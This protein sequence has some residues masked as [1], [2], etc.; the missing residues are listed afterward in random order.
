MSYLNIPEEMRL[1]PQ[2]IVWRY[3]ET[4]GDKPT[5]VPYQAKSGN[6]ASVDNPKHWTDF[7]T[8]IAAAKL[9]KYD[10]L[11]FVFTS[12]DNF[13]GIDLDDT[14]GDQVAY[15]RQ[16]KVYQEFDS[17][18]EL[19][20]SGKGL[21]IIVK[22]SI[23]CGRRRSKIE[24]YSE[25]RFFTMTGVVNRA[26]PIKDHNNLLNAL[27]NQM[28]AGVATFDNGI[29]RE[30]TQS[31]ADIILQAS[32]AMNGVKFQTLHSG[33]WQDVYQSQ[34]EA[35]LAYIDIIAFY[36]Q[37]REQITRLFR[38]SPLGQRDKAKRKDY[39][40][41]MIGRS[42]DK[43][44][45]DIDLDGLRNA[46]ELWRAQSAS[47]SPSRL[48]VED[49]ALA[50][51]GKLRSPTLADALN[52]PRH[53]PARAIADD[54][55]QGDNFAASP[56][57]PIQTAPTLVNP[58]AY[59][60]GLIGEIAQW[61]EDAAP[62]PVKEIALCGAIGFMAGVA[63]RAYNISGTGLNQYI[64]LLAKTGRGKEAMSSG[65]DKLVKAVKTAG[66][67]TIE[68]FVGPGEVA[69]AQAL[70][71]YMSNGPKCFYSLS[72]E[73][74]LL[75]HQL[76]GDKTPPHMTGLKSIIL[77]LY[78]KSGK[79]SS[80]KP[81]IYSD[82]TNNTETID[83]PSFTW[84]GEGTPETFYNSLEESTL[85]GGFLPRFTIIE[86][87]G[88]RVPLSEERPQEPPFALTDKVAK[89]VAQCQ[90]IMSKD[91]VINVPTNRAALQ[92]AKDF[93]TYCD[94]MI[95][96]NEDEVTAEL[97]N[98]AHVKML[99]MAAL[100][101][102]GINPF[103]PVID[104]NCIEW[105]KGIALTDVQNVSNKFKSGL[106]GANTTETKQAGDMLK[107]IHQYLNKPL[108]EMGSYDIN[109]VL[110]SEK[111]ITMSYLN[112][113][114]SCVASF[115]NDPLRA[116]KAIK[117]MLQSLVDQGVLRQVPEVKMRSFG[118]TAIGYMVADFRR[119]DNL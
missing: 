34:S 20:P 73:I 82:K 105:A 97:W 119:L 66:V 64:I 25:G 26:L 3:E 10:G 88:L 109:A 39:V 38:A 22:G 11:G 6:P 110:Y 12:N 78:N 74:G 28:G 54:V 94:N 29:D 80:L 99:K 65:L 14:N 91:Q 63:G 5:K 77:D 33:N 36:T 92:M 95:N 49:R 62:R 58:Y 40:S 37:N 44:L 85:S 35:D 16:L 116:T 68:D 41:R 72:G 118:T 31:D 81:R 7:A 24:I 30:Q 13:A 101:A 47:V 115:K 21:H 113:R 103:A 60:P 57:A 69:S 61:I 4:D 111:I 96:S 106:V 83:S 79:G 108:S 93:D 32:T 114:L 59:P 45:P 100:V 15:A 52:A 70:I 90:A 51:Q 86:Y 23:P 87:K 117:A 48:T 107:V 112:K 102:V 42:L 55:N 50:D 2:W 17:Y 18:S 53:E 89:F 9:T 46:A 98:R 71:K 8:A 43:Q 84:I 27:F 104:E 75:L 19:S 1:L 67:H 76:C 56:I